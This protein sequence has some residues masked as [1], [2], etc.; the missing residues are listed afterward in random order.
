MAREVFHS[1]RKRLKDEFGRWATLKRRA[2]WAFEKAHPEY[3]IGKLDEDIEQISV[4]RADAKHSAD[5]WNATLSNLQ[6]ELGSNPSVLDRPLIQKDIARAKR[7]KAEYENEAAMCL[8]HINRLLKWRNRIAKKH[9][10]K[11]RK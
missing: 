9:G 1:N 6:V 2:S 8:K 3:K 5:Q 10:I 11:L 4:L 7:R